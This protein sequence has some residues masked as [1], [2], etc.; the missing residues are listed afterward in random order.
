MACLQPADATRMRPDSLNLAIPL[1]ELR[2]QATPKD[3]H[4]PDL[5]QIVSVS[6]AVG[7]TN[8]TQPTAF[9]LQRPFHAT[10]P[11]TGAIPPPPQQQLFH[12]PQSGG[13]CTPLVVL[14][15]KSSLQHIGSPLAARY[16]ILAVPAEGKT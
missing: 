11:S 10:L 4:I 2:E 13:S 14:L 9:L 5:A 16:R 3:Y 8:T 7:T 6:V 12:M 1:H 15:A